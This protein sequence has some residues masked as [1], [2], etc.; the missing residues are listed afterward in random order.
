MIDSVDPI[1][2]VVISFQSNEDILSVGKI[3]S[4]M[5]FGGIEF[6]GLEESIH[7][8]IPCMYIPSPILGLRIELDGYK[9]FNKEND[10]WYS[11]YIMYDAEIISCFEDK[12]IERFTFLNKELKEDIKKML[13]QLDNIYLID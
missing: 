9:G 7:E 11:L 2:C 10:E 12:K 8:E 6:C 5:L 13:M 4:D 3:I 1:D